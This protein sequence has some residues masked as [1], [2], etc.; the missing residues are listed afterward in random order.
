MAVIMNK[1]LIKLVSILIIG[2]SMVLALGASSIHNKFP[3]IRGT[4]TDGTQNNSVEL[5]EK[6][7]VIGSRIQRAQ[8]SGNLAGM[9]SVMQSLTTN[10]LQIVNPNGKIVGADV[11]LESV[12]VSPAR[13]VNLKTKTGSDGE[14]EF[15]GVPK[16]TYRI[17]AFNRTP[18]S[19]SGLSSYI[20]VKK[21]RR[22]TDQVRL[23]ISP[24]AVTVAGRIVD[25]AG[26][27]IKGVKV[28]AKQGH[29]GVSRP[30]GDY[31]EYYHEVSAC[32]DSNGTYVLKGLIPAN[33]REAV[34][35][36]GGGYGD[37]DIWYT[38]N[39]EADGY[40]K[41]K[42]YIPVVPESVREAAKFVYEKSKKSVDAYRK[43][44][45]KNSTP[46]LQPECKENTISGVD[47]TLFK[48]ARIT[49]VVSGAFGEPNDGCSVWIE[50]TNRV[51]HRFACLPH[52]QKPLRANVNDE[53][54]FVIFDVP[55]D[56][57]WITI[58][59]KGRRI[60]K[61][62]DIIMIEEAVQLNDVNLAYDA[63]PFGHIEGLV[64]DSE[65]GGTVKD[66][67]IYVKKVTNPGEYSPARG[68]VVYRDGRHRKWKDGVLQKSEESSSGFL[69]EN[70]SPGKALLVVK[71]PGY[72]EE[73]VEVEVQS[74]EIA[75]STVC[76]QREAVVHVRCSVENRKKIDYYTSVSGKPPLVEY[77][78]VAEDGSECVC[79][80]KPA[81][82]AGYDNLIGLRPGAY[83]LRGD[84]SYLAGSVSRYETVPMSINAK[85]INDVTIDFRGVCEIKLLLD[86]S[87]G[88]YANAILETADT[89]SGN[90]WDSNSVGIRA[91]AHFRKPA[92]VVIPDLKPGRYRLSLF[93]HSIEKK[94]DERL[95]DLNPEEVR[96]FKLTEDDK[97][98]GFEIYLN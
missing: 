72:V 8:E 64:T 30:E 2:I 46:V 5:L 1:G 19:C 71:A 41:A 32:T 56:T 68:N 81:K 77:I 76:L 51:D 6:Y 96:V 45:M 3:D 88:F 26:K 38:L 47:F 75:K 36:E 7:C 10:L 4:V 65:S 84:I 17:S 57:Y 29:G 35:L 13:A 33:F 78:A 12:G 97:I 23:I 49:G 90:E 94:K 9:E 28:N 22:S 53:G 54:R 62:K 73:L 98:Q 42:N 70:I 24:L 69:V 58:S 74:A 89:P 61:R 82:N 63:Q 15:F 44:R 85:L 16:G 52:P 92:Q 55:P 95:T 34:G 43:A 20:I 39:V 93:K 91:R 18:G 40:I 50:A 83:T 87:P 31:T 14:F 11:I 79:K 59:E 86:F 60:D 80:G 48:P 27:P 66:F 37:K 25:S 21:Y 67:S